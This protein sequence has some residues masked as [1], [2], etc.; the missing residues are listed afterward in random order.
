MSKNSFLDVFY[1][2]F[3]SID[4]IHSSTAGNFIHFYSLHLTVLCHK[5]YMEIY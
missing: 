5:I 3:V 2:I 4:K 1:G